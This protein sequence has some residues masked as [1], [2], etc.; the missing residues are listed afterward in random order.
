MV[1]KPVSL[2]LLALF[3][4]AGCGG[5]GGSSGGSPV[6]DTTAVRYTL[7]W[8]ARTK[9]IQGPSSAL[10]ATVRL[11]GAAPAPGDFVQTVNRRV[12]PD[13]YEETYTSTTEANVGVFPM[14]VQF[15][16][17]PNGTGQVVAT[18]Y[19]NV[20]VAADGSGIGDVTTTATIASVTVTPHQSV[21]VGQTR[22][23][24]YTAKDANGAVVAVSPGSELWTVTA[25]GGVTVTPDGMATGVEWGNS[26]V[27]VSVDGVSS[28]DMLVTATRPAAILD[29]GFENAQIPAGQTGDLPLSWRADP[30]TKAYVISGAGIWGSGPYSGQN[31]LAFHINEGADSRITQTVGNLVVGQR[32]KFRAIYR[33]FVNH[34]PEALVM[35]RVD[36]RPGIYEAIGGGMSSADA[37]N[38]MQHYG[39]F[40]AT[41]TTHTIEIRGRTFYPHELGVLI[42]DVELV[43]AD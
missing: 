19:S 5:S 11:A 4:L 9:A 35:V 17:G 14:T 18:A 13:A 21:P 6:T 12:A 15:W 38:G 36:T 7:G 43:E 20:T 34:P 26:S 2:G 41:S 28:A 29:G 24:T 40:V 37:W 27:Q 42:D 10:S 8:G 16:S 33:S 30:G 31:A 39:S 3:V 22:P 23:L 32:Y 25:A 1:K